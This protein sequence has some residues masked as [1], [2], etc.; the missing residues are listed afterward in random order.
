VLGSGAKGEDAKAGGGEFHPPRDEEQ[1]GRCYQH[2][3]K[4]RLWVP[5]EPETTGGAIPA[6]GL[7]NRGKE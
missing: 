2:H 7:H 3:F 4:E 1:T 5:R 6:Y